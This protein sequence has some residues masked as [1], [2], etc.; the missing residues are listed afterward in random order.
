MKCLLQQKIVVERNLPLS[1]TS[2]STG[3]LRSK[4]A[5]PLSSSTTGTFRSKLANELA[6][7]STGSNTTGEWNC[8]PC[9]QLVLANEQSSTQAHATRE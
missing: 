4:V 3:S 7:R 5:L 6:M 2:S 9:V 8:W 1:L